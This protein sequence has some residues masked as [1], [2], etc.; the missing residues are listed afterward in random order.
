MFETLD[1][2]ISIGVIYL[3]LS[4]AHKYIISIFKRAINIRGNIV[5]R[6]MSTI[7]G[8]YS[9]EYLLAYLKKNNKYTHLLDKK[10]K[11]ITEISCPQMKFIIEDMQQ[12]FNNKNNIESIR[13]SLG[14]SETVDTPL[15]KEFNRLKAD[16]SLWQDNI[17][18]TYDNTMKRI[19][20]LTESKIRQWTL[21]LGVVFALA[22]NA[23]FM[24]IYSTLSQNNDARMRL[25]AN[26]ELISAKLELME[27]VRK[28]K[29]VSQNDSFMNI[30]NEL[31][32]TSS[33]M[34]KELADSALIFGWH[35]TDLSQMKNPLSLLNK[36]IGILISALLISFGAPFWHDYLS[37]FVNIRKNLAQ[38]RE[39]GN[40]K[41]IS[42]PAHNS[43]ET[44]SNR[45]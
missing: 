42:Q 20:A 27:K 19:S 37:T 2:L 39:T 44:D 23:D 31:L 17:T 4:M 32:E 5:A 34:K 3:I 45:L 28:K 41:S 24:Q 15:V 40:V 12:F 9:S 6:E 8:N 43:S 35:D 25:V 13:K 33:E 7:L 11:K 26:S 36:I 1:T 21:A 22:M 30:K 29:A 16:L 14:L 10:N 18:H 38:N